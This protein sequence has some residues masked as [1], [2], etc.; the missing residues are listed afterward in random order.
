[1][2][3]MDTERPDLLT[4]LSQNKI[5]LLYHPILH[6]VDGPEAKKLFEDCK[7]GR[8]KVDIF[9]FEGTIPTKEGCGDWPGTDIK[10]LVKDL[11]SKAGITIALGTCASFGGIPS[12]PPN[13]SGSVGLQ[14]HG[15]K[16]GGWLGENY[17]SEQ[18]APV[19]NIPGCPAHPDW[20]IRTIQ[21]FVLEK[22]VI[23]DDYNRPKDFFEEKAHRG[24]K[25]CEFHERGLW[26]EEFTETG[27]LAAKL[28]CK[29][30]TTNA[31]CNVRLWNGVSSCTRS[32]APCIGCCDP[33]FPISM[34]PFNKETLNLP[35][36]VRSLANE[37]KKIL[38]GD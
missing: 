26:A 30:R 23:L 37:K 7:E 22:P 14:F 20:I 1:M 32:G 24:C 2:A 28:G 19:I 17:I 16:K 34:T 9:I 33:G 38:Y 6:P 4:F 13:E 25:Q 12:A 21:A 29:G 31:D 11:A 8:T 15:H 27:C 18:G 35:E 36:D 3:I 5:K 10:T